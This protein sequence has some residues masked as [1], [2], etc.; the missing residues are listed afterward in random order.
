MSCSS[1]C[2]EQEAHNA[3][4]RFVHLIRKSNSSVQMDDF[5]IHN[6]VGRY[7]PLLVLSHV[8]SQL[9]RVDIKFKIDLEK[10]NMDHSSSCSYDAEIFPGLTYRMQSPDV[11]LLVFHRFAY[12]C[13]LTFH[14]LINST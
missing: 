8:H 12:A 10:L 13:L 3:A 4:E 9:S 7:M 1:L 6:V 5:K 2:S 14:E 11:V